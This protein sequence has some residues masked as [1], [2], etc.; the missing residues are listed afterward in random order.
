M[1]VSRLTKMTLLAE[2][3]QH[4]AILQSLQSIQ[5][6]EIEDIF[7]SEENEAWLTTY[8]PEIEEIDQAMIR[9]YNYW[10]TQIEQGITFIRDHGSSKKKLKSCPVRI[11]HYK[12]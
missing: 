2:R 6:V 9:E 10:L 12:H 3:K 4:D 5:N 8:F 1:A 11:I 7:D